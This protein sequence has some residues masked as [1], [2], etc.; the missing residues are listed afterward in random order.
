M[1][2]SKQPNREDQQVTDYQAPEVESH[3]EEEEIEREVAYA[4]QTQP[5]LGETMLGGGQ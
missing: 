2:D 3:L 4:G 5:T 1:P